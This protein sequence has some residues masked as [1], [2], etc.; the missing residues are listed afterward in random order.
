M[1]TCTSSVPGKELG[2]NYKDNVSYEHGEFI[3]SFVN[4]LLNS[5]KSV[6]F[7]REL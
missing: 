3:N 2:R 7:T 5:G 6:G 4:Y 1:H